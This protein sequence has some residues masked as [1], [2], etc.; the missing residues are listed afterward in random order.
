[1][2]ITKNLRDGQLVINDGTG[3]PLT[4]TLALDEG[5]LSFTINQNTIQ[6]RDRGVLSHTRPGD[7]ATVDMSFSAKWVELLGATLTVPTEDTLYEMVNNVDDTYTSTSGAGEQYTLEYVFTITDPA[8]G[9]TTD[10]QITFAK[11]YKTSFVCAE[12]DE[13]NTMSYTGVDFETQPTIEYV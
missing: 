3:T 5:D 8:G 2:P 10:Q 12:G 1:M 4:L 13:Y 6:V 11:C 7:Q 9:A